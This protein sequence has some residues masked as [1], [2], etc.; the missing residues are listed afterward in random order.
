MSFFARHKSRYGTRRLRVALHQKAIGWGVRP[1]ARP[2]PAGACGPC[3]PRPTR[4]APRTPPMGFRCAP[5]RLLDQPKPT[6]ANRVWVSD[7]TYLPLFNGA[8]AYFVRLSGRGQQT[9]RGLA[10]ARHDA[11][12]TGHD[13]AAAGSAGPVAHPTGYDPRPGGAFRPRGGSTAATPIGPCS[14]GTKPCARKAGVASATTTPYRVRPKP[15]AAGPAS[16]PKNSNG[17]SGPFSPT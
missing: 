5:N 15:K 8:W 6:Q 11:R 4:R 12:S 1:C 13:G 10:R 14:T 16:K 17:P 3:S 7:I 9:R 2:W